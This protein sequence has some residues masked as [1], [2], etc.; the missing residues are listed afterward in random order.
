MD[1]PFA[2]IRLLSKATFVFCRPSW[3]FSAFGLAFYLYLR[4]LPPFFG[5]CPLL[6]DLFL[7]LLRR[8]PPIVRASLFAATWLI[9]TATPV[10]GRLTTR[11]LRPS[12]NSARN[13]GV[14]SP[15]GLPLLRQRRQF[16]QI[17][18]DTPLLPPHDTVPL[19]LPQLSPRQART[20]TG[21][22][23][24]AFVDVIVVEHIG[25]QGLV[26]GGEDDT[27][28][29]RF[30]GILQGV[31]ARQVEVVG[32]LLGRDERE[33]EVVVDDL[34]TIDDGDLSLRESHLD[35]ENIATTKYPVLSEG[36][37]GQQKKYIG[38]RM[39]QHERSERPVLLHLKMQPHKRSN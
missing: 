32:G 26:V 2:A 35:Q 16:L 39:G 19:D 25:D 5:T 3:L 15:P 28:S 38:F 34:S 11:C 31:D 20:E 10:P 13:G 14:R 29:V 6:S 37:T 8:P 1:R 4:L 30:K 9:S 7:P 17:Q 18:G 23:S 12:A 24:P 36:S 22:R 21:T 27:A 33:E